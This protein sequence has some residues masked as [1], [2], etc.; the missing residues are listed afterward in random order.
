MDIEIKIFSFEVEVKPVVRE[1]NL[2]AFVVWRFKTSVGD[3]KIDGGTIRRKP[4]GK[5]GEEI[6]TYD[7]PAIRMRFGFRKVFFI[8]NIKLYQQLCNFTVRQYEEISGSIPSKKK[9]VINIEDI[10]L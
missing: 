10:P 5:N 9:E 4:F 6:A 7:G 1:D 3:F 8:D 2:L